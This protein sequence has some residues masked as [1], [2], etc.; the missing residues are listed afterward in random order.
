LVTALLAGPLTGETSAAL[1]EIV[2]T[3]TIFFPV[4][5][6]SL[7]FDDTGDALFELSELVSFSG[8]TC[9]FCDPTID[10]NAIQQVPTIPNISKLSGSSISGGNEWT[11]LNDA[12]VIY[13][14]GI[15]RLTYVSTDIAQIPEP[16]TLGLVGLGI[17][18]AALARRRR[19]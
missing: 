2:A 10:F 16:A 17:A 14:V 1:M 15:G 6:F 18:G 12:G 7:T 3:P 5:N 8:I 13:S 4:D 11:F 19:K 9:L